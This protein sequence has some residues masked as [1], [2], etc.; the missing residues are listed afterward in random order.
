VCVV[1]LSR[2]GPSKESFLSLA[3]CYMKFLRAP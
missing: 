3:A 2:A 1:S